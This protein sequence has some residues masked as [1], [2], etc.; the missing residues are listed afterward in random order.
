MRRCRFGCCGRNRS[1]V[2][3]YII[4]IYPPEGVCKSIHL[5]QAENK[6]DCQRREHLS[7]I[8][9]NRR[10]NRPKNICSFTFSLLSRDPI[11]P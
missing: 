9:N 8:T 7:Y 6:R 10:D 3:K 2:A 11:E 5:P 1:G 4:I